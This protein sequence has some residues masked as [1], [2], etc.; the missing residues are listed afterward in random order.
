MQNTKWEIPNTNTN[1]GA[2]TSREVMG[3]RQRGRAAK[4]VY[5]LLA[6]A[7]FSP[8]EIRFVRDFKTLSFLIKLSL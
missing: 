3:G 8:Q 4:W 7:G 5:V 2:N 6:S 1:T